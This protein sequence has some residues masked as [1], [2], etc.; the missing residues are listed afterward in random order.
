[1][2]RH[3]D[4]SNQYD[5]GRESSV[6]P[7]DVI[8]P[9]Q[10]SI[11]LPSSSTF[12]RPSSS[13]ASSSS[14]SKAKVPKGRLDSVS[15][16]SSKSRPRG[17]GRTI[18]SASRSA[19][20][21]TSP[22]KRGSSSASSNRGTGRPRG[23]PRGSKSRS[24]E[25][26]IRSTITDSQPDNGPVPPNVQGEIEEQN[27]LDLAR[28]D[29]IVEKKYEEIVL[30]SESDEEESTSNHNE[31]NQQQ[32][33]DPDIS[34]TFEQ[35]KAELETQSPME[36]E[37]SEN[38]VLGD[39]SAKTD[40]VIVEEASESHHEVE[41]INPLRIVEEAIISE[42]TQ[43]AVKDREEPVESLEP[44]HVVNSDLV[45]HEEKTED[46]IA[47]DDSNND[48]PISPQSQ[49]PS[50]SNQEKHHLTDQTG[51][52]SPNTIYPIASPPIPPTDTSN[53]LPPA[54]IGPIHA[55]ETPFDNS[56]TSESLAEQSIGNEKE[57]KDLIKEDITTEQI[58][59]LDPATTQL[60]IDKNP[61]SVK[62]EAAM[63]QKE[64]DLQLDQ[65][66][67][68]ETLIEGKQS[69]ENAP[70]VKVVEI[71]TPENTITENQQ[72]FMSAL[73]VNEGEGQA[74]EDGLQMQYT[75]VKEGADK[76][77][78]EIMLEEDK[79]NTDVQ[80]KTAS[81]E[82]EAEVHVEE[83]K[84]DVDG[85]Q[86][87]I[88]SE[89]VEFAAIEQEMVNS[90]GDEE[91]EMEIDGIA[92][93]DQAD[94]EIQVEEPKEKSKETPTA[95]SS[96]TRLIALSPP[97]TTATP[98]PLKKNSTATGKKRGPVPGSK[99]SSTPVSSGS[100]TA[101]VKKSVGRPKGKTKVEEL[102]A[103]SKP[104]STISSSDDSPIPTTPT[105]S[106]SMMNSP[107]PSPD[108]NAIYCVCR[109]PY[110]DEDDDITMVGCE[111]CDNWFHPKCIG[112]TDDMVEAVDAYICKTCERTT[113]QKTV[114]KQLCKR[115]GC[116]KA[117]G[118]SSSK[119][120]S[121]SCAYQHSQAL[122]AA[123]SNKNTLKQL[124]KT[125]IS[126]PKPELSIQVEQHG[127][128]TKTRC[129]SS[130]ITT[131]NNAS[132]QLAD[133]QKQL[134]KVEELMKLVMKR[135][136]ILRLTIDKSENL[137]LVINIVEEEEELAERKK[138][139]K[140]K[141]SSGVNG[142][143]KEDKPCGWN[144]KL[145]LD[146]HD[147]MNL[148]DSEQ[149]QTSKTDGNNDDASNCL[150]TETDTDSGICLRGRRK[151]DRHQ[152]WQKTIAVQLEVELTNLELAQK[153]LNVYI[154]SLK[155][156]SE[157]RSLTE[158]IRLVHLC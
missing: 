140:K 125:F 134:E 101:I 93:V 15:I 107:N 92:E 131:T 66:A 28:N 6:D 44:D 130:R 17:R 135:Q 109:K 9:P 51:V 30:S 69:P 142:G 150:G 70:I 121:S 61:L 29:V 137:P 41:D 59:E 26:R 56:S 157:E 84:K 47:N 123:L 55:A 119:F 90:V 91:G 83:D 74:Q 42:E 143:N 141:Y 111:S 19:S 139:K 49:S 106:L 16:P 46:R 20:R 126:Y 33:I 34:V 88:S 35:Q 27:T 8:S 58:E 65:S 117:L 87:V 80:A 50:L 78:D 153:N 97:S 43:E 2:G 32:L 96:P 57:P 116:K 7:L 22:T 68:E 129:K 155:T 31:D 81:V 11:P 71:Q 24:P 108:K 1:M 127:D 118:G 158:Q 4:V 122:L 82:A 37:T 136:E 21:S 75:E 124:A 152:G 105:R 45:N 85:V 94:E 62:G 148:P 146:D 133:L 144:Q 149:D 39:K 120:C 86:E 151:C 99:K 52:A 112:L 156:S 48:Q 36:I 23:R 38:V 64:E 3:L 103:V 67:T 25:K 115:E 95:P 18:T 76:P 114:W 77:N 63:S 98:K 12:P 54:S 89:S 40:Q 100:G 138:G 72:P 10:R 60:P 73:R 5:S 110:E 132:E 53:I 104:L 13:S 128:D 79:Q 145:I 147:I 102:K 113:H 154:D 14:T